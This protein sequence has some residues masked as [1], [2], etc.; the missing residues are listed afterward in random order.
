VTNDL[1]K[2]DA[3]EK[4]FEDIKD[5]PTLPSVVAQ[6]MV[7]LNEP[8]SSARDLERL[9]AN[10]E[11]IT[12]KLLKL[13]NSVFYGLPGKVNSL[14]RA[15]TL[16]GFNTVRSMVLTIGVVDKFAGASGNEYFNRGD[17]WEHSLSV[18]MAS[19]LLTSKDAAINPDEAHIAGLLHD[20]GKMIFDLNRPK[21]Y[22]DA[23]LSIHELNIDELVAERAAIGFS[24]DEVGAMIA[25]KWRFP[26]FIREAAAFHHDYQNATGFPA[27]VQAVSLANIIVNSFKSQESSGQ[28]LVIPEID[29]QLKA[30]FLPSPM[31]EEVFLT[32][33]EIEV[34]KVQDILNLFV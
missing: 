29:P 33:F 9:I 12:A 8:S 34:E 31:H 21:E 22:R 27:V 1:S 13:A 14:N 3:R 28:D 30:R 24:H 5:L 11:A 17:F 15:I 2:Q 18:A 19:K 10:D 20:L 16:L 32:K 4:F 26:E 25:D 7:T 6:V 23:L